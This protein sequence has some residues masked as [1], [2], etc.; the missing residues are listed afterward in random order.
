MLPDRR[1]KADLAQKRD[2]HRDS[3]ERSHGALGFPQ[4]HPLIRQQGVDLARDRFVRSIGFHSLVV[5]KSPAAFP[6]RISVFR[7]IIP[8]AQSCQEMIAQKVDLVEGGGAAGGATRQFYESP[9]SNGN[10]G[11]LAAYDVQTLKEMWK[12]EQ[13]APF[14]TA[15]LSTAGGVAFVGDMNRMFRAV[16]AKTGKT[17]WETRLE[18]S[19]QG[20][21]LTFSIGGRQYIAVTT[22]LGG[23]SP[24]IVPAVLAGDV[25]YPAYGNTLHVFALPERR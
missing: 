3:S 12:V 18:T 8:L 25:K 20:F 19:V 6:V 1:Y 16:D 13:R 17:L 5:S 15:V 10:I 23:G 4:D 9:G 2:E 11:K 7:L 21:P 22:G 24:R 14:M